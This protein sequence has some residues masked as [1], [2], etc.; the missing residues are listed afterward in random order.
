ME[1]LK[2]GQKVR[3]KSVE[4]DGVITEIWSARGDQ[5]KYKV[6]YY[7]TNKRSIA[8]WYIASDLMVID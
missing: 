7:D 4:L 6:Q 8:P 5:T 1:E 2:L 3:I